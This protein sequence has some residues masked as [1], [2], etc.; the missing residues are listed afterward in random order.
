MGSVPALPRGEEPGKTLID[1]Y[2]PRSDGGVY[3]VRSASTNGPNGNGGGANGAK[4]V[5]RMDSESHADDH[6]HYM[7]IP[8]LQMV[9]HR[10]PWLL[11]LMIVQ[12][13]S[14]FVVARYE[15][16]IS[17]HVIIASFLTMLVGGG[18]NSSG[19]TVAEL[20]KRLRTREITSRDFWRVFVKESTAGLLLSIGLG[21]AAF[22]RVRYM[23]R[24]ATNAD[25]FAIA[26]SYTLIVVMANGL[27]VCITM[28]LHMF[29][30]AA[31]GSPPVVQVLVDVIGISLTC[32]VCSA[33]LEG[34]APEPQR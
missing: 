28:A 2:M 32:L 1:P 24:G 13:V 34:T 12:S 7:E 3:L 6:G 17:E 20:V 16:L 5:M 22:P 10:L 9:S 31:V 33:V 29:G 8:V 19:Q 26:L 18:G 15:N 4:P 21:L 23:H 14:G 27:G 30:K 11:A 25:A